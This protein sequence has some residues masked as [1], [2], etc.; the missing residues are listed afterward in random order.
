MWVLLWEDSRLWGESAGPRTGVGRAQGWTGGIQLCQRQESCETPETVS[1]RLKRQTEGEEEKRKQKAKQKK[2]KYN[3]LE[4]QCVIQTLR[5]VQKNNT[6]TKPKTP[7][8]SPYGTLVN[9]GRN[10]ALFLPGVNCPRTTAGKIRE[11]SQCRRV[12]VTGVEGG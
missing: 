2:T 1:Q 12:Q 10:H 6:T 3:E 11:C 5:I 9:K 4:N 7:H 8:Q